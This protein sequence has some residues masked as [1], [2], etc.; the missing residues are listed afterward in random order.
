MVPTLYLQAS[1]VY[2]LTNIALNSFRFCFISNAERLQPADISELYM[3]DSYKKMEEKSCSEFDSFFSILRT[4]DY[5]P[6]ETVRS[7]PKRL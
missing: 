5:I 2:V 4:I 6:L 7:I 1:C 3:C